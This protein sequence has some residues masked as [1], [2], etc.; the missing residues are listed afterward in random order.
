MWIR[1]ACSAGFRVFRFKGFNQR[2]MLG[3]GNAPLIGIAAGTKQAERYETFHLVGERFKQGAKTII[4]RRR[5]KFPMEG[6]IALHEGELLNFAAGILGRA[7]DGT[8]FD[9]VELASR[10]RCCRRFSDQTQ[11]EQFA[12]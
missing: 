9:D 5:C 4:A 11:L 10:Q 8:Q 12:A 3:V 2:F 6:A 1:A 7:V